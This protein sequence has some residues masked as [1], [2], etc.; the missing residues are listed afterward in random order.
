[1]IYGNFEALVRK[2]PGCE[3][4]PESKQK[5][6][7]EKTE[8]HEACGYAYKVVRSD[9]QVTGSGVYR[10]EN[11][12]GCF[13]EN[14][15]WEEEEIRKSLAAPKRIK[16]TPGDWKKFK[17]ATECHICE[18]GLGK[19]E[20]LNSLPVWLLDE[21]MDDY[22]Y[23]GQ[24]HKK[25]LLRR[26]EERLLPD[27]AE[28]GR[29]SNSSGQ[30]KCIFCRRPLLQKNYRYAVKDHYHITGKYRGVSPQ[31]MQ[32]KTA[33]KAKDDANTSNISQPEGLRRAS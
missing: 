2:M 15:L 1:M 8:L 33:N 10:G 26:K 27:K 30:K 23:W 12:V 3:R 19:K 22:Q 5:S 11:A 4:G 16:M 9:D 20:S 24:S 31:R 25:M 6:Y 29:K 14:I 13:L 7:T 17:N 32:S 21:G 18:K 28:K